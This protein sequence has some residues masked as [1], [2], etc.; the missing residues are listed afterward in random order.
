[1]RL[2]AGALHLGA[3]FAIANCSG[4]SGAG[5]GTL[6]PCTFT[7]PIAPGADP[8]VVREND[9]YYFVAS[10][11]NAIWVQKTSKLTEIGSGGVKVWAAP[12]SGWNHTNVWAPELHHIDGRWYIYYAAGSSGPP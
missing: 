6:P 7:N 3:L 5:P 8:W 2:A 4:G 9:S 11:D 1:M 12:G 10:R